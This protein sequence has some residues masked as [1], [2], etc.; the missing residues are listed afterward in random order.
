[1]APRDRT[2][3]ATAG[4]Q[5]ADSAD[6]NGAIL[7]EVVESGPAGAAGI[8][9]EDVIRQFGDKAV[10]TA[11][12]LQTALA[13]KKPDDKVRVKFV[14]GKDE[15]EV[16]I[17]LA[18]R[19]AAPGFA[20]LQ[21]EDVDNEGGARVTDVTEGGPAERAGIKVGDVIS[22]VGDKVIKNCEDFQDEARSRQSGDKLKVEVTRDKKKSTIELTLGQRPGFGGGTGGGGLGGGGRRRRLRARRCDEYT[23]VCRQ[24]R[25]A[26]RERRRSGARQPRIRRRLQV[27]GRRRLLDTHQ[28]RQPATHV[29]QSGPRRSVG[30]QAPVCPRH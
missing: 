4:W 12:E 20:G 24:L 17:T 29:L 11:A 2:A 18:G 28:Q 9:A 10:K 23:A 26:T 25:R 14:R 5:A 13:A 22:R 19:R 3:V 21:G 27:H 16:E 7:T 6:K 15:K 30:R 8:K 1:M